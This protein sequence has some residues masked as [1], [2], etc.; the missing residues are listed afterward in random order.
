MT[1]I[2]DITPQQDD[3]GPRFDPFNPFTP[4]IP[5]WESAATLRE[6]N[7]KLHQAITEF[8]Q[9]VANF[10]QEVKDL[11]QENVRERGAIAHA[12]DR[13]VRAERER[14]AEH[15]ARLQAHT[16]IEKARNH[17][18]PD[19]HPGW[20]AEATNELLTCDNAFE[21]QK[22]EDQ[23]VGALLARI[24][25]DGGHRQDEV[26]T[27]QAIKEAEEKAIEMIGKLTAVWD[28]VK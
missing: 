24:H 25:R 7:E 14:D 2:G 22:V 15:R 16:L 27:M 23:A 18:D 26:G 4:I 17:I 13:A 3:C 8:K 12:Y 20:D 1:Q 11:T 9:M 19:E 10:Q 21:Q 28:I 5:R 6:E